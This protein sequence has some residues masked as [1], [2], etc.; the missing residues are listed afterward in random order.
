MSSDGLSAVTRREFPVVV[1]KAN[2]MVPEVRETRV[3]GRSSKA[4]TC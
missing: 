1:L 2:A 4:S 3:D